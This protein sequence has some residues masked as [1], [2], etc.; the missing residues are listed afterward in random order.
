MTRTW[1][2][3]GIEPEVGDFLDDEVIQAVLERDGLTDADFHH[4]VN[5]ARRLLGR[6]TQH[7]CAV[8]TPCCEAA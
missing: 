4:H 1:A 5:L 8:D 3:A 7:A 6:R 2:Q